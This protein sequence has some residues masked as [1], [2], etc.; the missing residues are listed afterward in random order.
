MTFFIWLDPNRKRNF[1]FPLVL[2]GFELRA[3][4]LPPGPLHQVPKLRGTDTWF[5]VDSQIE[6][7]RLNKAWEQKSREMDKQP[8]ES[9]EKW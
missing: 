6:A 9:W 5:Y 4:A 2:L 3:G 1:F 7:N 8:P